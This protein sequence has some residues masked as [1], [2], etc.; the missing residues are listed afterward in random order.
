M[1]LLYRFRGLAIGAL[2]GV[3]YS[4]VSQERKRLRERIGRDEALSELM[5]RLER[6]LSTIKI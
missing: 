4:S 5:Q 6:G 1:D 3:D 2:F